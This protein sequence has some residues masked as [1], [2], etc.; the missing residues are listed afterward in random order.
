[1]K[2]ALLGYGRMGKE[3]EKI[4]LQRGH[5]I[6]I[7]ASGTATYDITK[8]DVAI[9]FSI[10]DAA[11][12]NISHC[13]NNQIPVI[14]GTTGWLEKYDSI[15]ELCNQKQ[16]AFIYAS[17]FSLGVNVFFELNKQ[18]AKM[19]Q[20]LDQYTI[21][22]EEIHHTKKLDA[23][24]GTAITLA[25]GI[26]ENSAKKAWEL[27]AKTSEENI[28]ITAIRT[29]DVPGTHTTTYDSIVDS[30][31]IKHTAHNRQGFAL[32]AVIAAEW[33]A[34]KTGVFTMRDVLNLG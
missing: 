33:L 10:P 5:E 12:N 23:P 15:V 24:S 34:D 6:I 3:I 1:M 2:I 29:P 16:G 26:I 20:T 31:A 18:L 21:S 30:I 7:K 14:S 32:G 25:E 13:V 22:I 27:D 9:D 4:A 17:N 19:M 11:F 28:P 8:A